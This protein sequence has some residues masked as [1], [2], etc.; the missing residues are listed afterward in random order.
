MAIPLSKRGRINPNDFY[1]GASAAA[2][3]DRNAALFNKQAE[4]IRDAAILKRK[5]AYEAE[6]MQADAQ[7]KAAK[8]LEDQVTDAFYIPETY[9]DK[10]GASQ[11]SDYLN[12]IWDATSNQLMD[13][14]VNI[15]QD[16]DMDART[17]SVQMKKLLRHVPMMKNA[18][19]LLNNRINEFAV[20]SIQGDVSKTMEPKFQQ[21]YAD[22]LN[23]EF[24]GGIVFE[25]DRMVLRGA[26][27]NGKKINLDLQD[28]EAHLP[29]TTAKMSSITDNL[30]GYDNTWRKRQNAYKSG[31][32]PENRQVWSDDVQGKSIRDAMNENIAKFGEKGD[33]AFALDT[34]GLD[35]ATYEAMWKAELN[36]VQEQGIVSDE[37]FK[38][39]LKEYP[40][41]D[42]E[43]VAKRLQITN[44]FG[45]KAY[46]MSEVEAKEKVT[47][48]LMNEYVSV[49]KTQFDRQKY[50][51]TIPFKPG[52]SEFKVR[53]QNQTE[54]FVKG[55]ADKDIIS[56]MGE[57]PANIPG[58]EA[59]TD[60]EFSDNGVLTYQHA[61]GSPK[62]FDRLDADG[63][64]IAIKDA[65]GNETGFQKE[66]GRH[67]KVKEFNFNDR[68]HVEIFWK[69]RFKKGKTAKEKIEVDKTWEQNGDRIILSIQDQIKELKDKKAK[70]FVENSG[71]SRIWRSKQMG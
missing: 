64:K 59:I 22:L 37:M 34:M 1:S 60:I 71:A 53:L 67:S 68:D 12:N 56:I 49:F 17:Q 11:T 69:E 26:T 15:A 61:Y 5:Q 44:R 36:S 18:K 16:K 10:E 20:G 19:A 42:A 7:T 28:F 41:T 52:P 48:D 54:R 66:W 70:E 57:I 39:M 65:E 27:S 63:N 46:K 35:A 8:V 62:Q 25:G 21:M 51:D 33:E 30:V 24:D 13:V 47:E 38:A 43:S 29:E 50:A 23:D 4:Q 45:P 55:L 6:K 40:G 32:Q 9:K 58:G 14:Y 2:A 31:G 3:G